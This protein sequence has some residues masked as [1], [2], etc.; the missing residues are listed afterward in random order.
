MD[1]ASS[2][3]YPGGRTLAGWWRQLAPRQPL[4]LWIGYAFLH[5]IEATVICRGEQPI[6][7]FTHQVLQ[8][9]ALEEMVASNHVPGVT[10][11]QVQDRLQLPLAV[12][13]RVLSGLERDGLLTR[14]SPERWQLSDCGRDALHNR[15]FP[16][17]MQKR[18]GFAFR[19]RLDCGGQRTEAP[20]FVPIADCAGSSWHVDEPHRF[21]VATLRACVEQSPDWKQASSF[22]LDVAAL[23]EYAALEAWQQVVID[24]PERVMLVLVAVQ[25]QGHREVHG[26]AAKVDGWTLFDRAPVVKVSASS[27]AAW[28]E[29]AHELGAEVWQEAW[30]NWCKQRQLPAN[31]VEICALKHVPPRLE[32][33][34]PPRL[35]QRLE[36]A[37]SDL[38]KGDAWIL[39]GDG[40][41]RTAVQ[42][43]MKT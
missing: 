1:R 37:K 3:I 38:F 34:A 21:D 7:P 16:V 30:R 31:E 28:P 8:A 24:R 5:R 27:M 10:S 41:F 9:A 17:R 4:G 12:V 19:E 25:C 2:L 14:P 32:V 15:S 39:V 36:A 33:Q 18:H 6:D 26:F 35:V 43:A 13:Q 40:F 42:L 29:I 23:P 11:I 22:P 20:H